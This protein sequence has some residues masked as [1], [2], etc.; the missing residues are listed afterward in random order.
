MSEFPECE[1]G[2]SWADKIALDGNF[3][4][5]T[6]KKDICVVSVLHSDLGCLFV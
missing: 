4:I 1:F 5:F 2:H 3:E 6:L